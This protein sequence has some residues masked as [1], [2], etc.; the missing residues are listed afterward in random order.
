MQ[1]ISHLDA[2]KKA[3]V[4]MLLTLFVYQFYHIEIIRAN[5]EDFAFDIINEFVTFFIEADTNSP[6]VMMFKFDNDYM[7]SS[8]LMD[9]NNET[10][11]GYIFPR[12]K[13][14]D[15]I[16]GV[17]EFTRNNKE[18]SP[19]MLFIDMDLSYPTNEESNVLSF[20]DKRLIDILKKERNYKILISK[21]SQH[22]FIEYFP[23]PILQKKIKD[24]ELIF[25]STSL[26]QAVDNISRRYYPYEQYKN[27]LSQD[28]YYPNA[29]VLMWAISNKKD[30]NY[31][32]K[33]FHTEKESL[34]ENRIIFK[35]VFKI[36]QNEYYNANQSLW[37]QLTMYSANYP[38]NEIPTEK[39]KNSILLIGSTHSASDDKFTTNSFVPEISGVEMHAN[40]LMTLFYLNGKMN[41][42]SLILTCIIV[43]SIVYTANIAI[44]KLGQN[45]A[46]V[47]QQVDHFTVGISVVLMLLCSVYFLLVHKLWFNWFI[48]SLITPFS[49]YFIVMNKLFKNALNIIQVFIIGFV[50]HITSKWFNSEHSGSK[51]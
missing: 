35:K 21:Q 41:R 15:F 40:A 26:T 10:T 36:D 44:Q 9:E 31:L 48:L 17:D 28:V 12:D 5:I 1:T 24:K 16:K 3:L 30:F 42:L 11:Y 13:L 29:A 39:F 37:Q 33:Y 47:K 4:T 14:S 49:I 51:K 2:S 43:F 20:K 18:N 27:N 23:D 7:K 25:V 32:T 6:N 46:V 50:V 34:I 38:L 45:Y 19:S 22:N 8:H